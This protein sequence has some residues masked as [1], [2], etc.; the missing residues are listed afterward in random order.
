MSAWDFCRLR[1]SDILYL[2]HLGQDIQE[3]D[4]V[5]RV[6][7]VILTAA[8]ADPQRPLGHGIQDSLVQLLGDEG[9]GKLPQVVL[10]H[11][12]SESERE[13][14]GERGRE[15]QREREKERLIQVLGK[16]LIR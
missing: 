14:E 7:Q 5:F 12:W 9:V 1:P 10:K 16:P 2:F 3:P 4:G 6:G 13:E 15:G 8:G 11:T